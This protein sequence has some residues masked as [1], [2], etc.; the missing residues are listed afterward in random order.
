[1]KRIFLFLMLLCIAITVRVQAQGITREDH[2]APSH[3][4]ATA[5]D[6]HINGFAIH[7]KWGKG[8][9]SNLR[10]Y[11]IDFGKMRHQKEFRY[12]A[13]PPYNGFV[14]GRTNI[15]MPLNFGFGK[16]KALG[17]RN[18]KNDV[19]LSYTLQ[20]GISLALLKPVYLY[21]DRKPG[22]PESNVELIR[23]SKESSIEYNNII[24][25][26]SFF[27]GLNQLSLIPGVFT[28]ASLVFNWGRYSGDFHAVETG[29]MLTAY[30]KALPL[31]A[32]T[33]NNMV[34]PSVYIAFNLGKYW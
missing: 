25:G 2:H 12:T 7:F 8:D 32:I 5:A 14:F 22:T 6:L 27:T 31:M 18:G 3:F 26:A 21:I 34:Y 23:Y 10:F 29:A 33:K 13:N 4:F 19:G 9:A 15:A 11:A 24:G 28:R 20:A 17:I 16:M 30:N 1:M